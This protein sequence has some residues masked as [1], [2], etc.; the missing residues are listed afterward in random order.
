MVE[1]VRTKLAERIENLGLI[2]PV[3]EI[4]IKSIESTADI[5]DVTESFKLTLIV[6]GRTMLFDVD[7]VGE[8]VNAYLDR[9]GG[10][11]M[12]EDLTSIEYVD[13]EFNEEGDSATFTLKID[14]QAAPQID[15]SEIIDNLLGKDEG[16]ITQY[17]RGLDEISSAKILLSPFWIKNV[18]KDSSRV[19]IDFEY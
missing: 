12:V 2:D 4:E 10:L 18:P 9:S 8:L 5:D 15:T 7:D 6:E 16:E 3:S 13:A 11:E 17:F 1:A 14:G 19:K